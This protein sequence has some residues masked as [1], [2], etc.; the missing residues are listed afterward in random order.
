[1]DL[2]NAIGPYEMPRLDI[3]TFEVE[4]G[5]AASS[6]DYMIIEPEDWIDSGYSWEQ[7]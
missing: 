7:D 6:D 3:Q 2:Q 4:A 5:F 1:M